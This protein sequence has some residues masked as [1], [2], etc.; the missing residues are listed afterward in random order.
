MLHP[1]ALR[2]WSV[3]VDWDA[4]SGQNVLEK[5]GIRWVDDYRRM[6]NITFGLSREVAR[7]GNILGGIFYSGLGD[8]KPSLG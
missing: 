4:K 3:L 8:Q 5:F 1:A 6:R 7:E 2:R